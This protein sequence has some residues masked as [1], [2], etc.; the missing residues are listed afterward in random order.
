LCDGSDNRGP[1]C[2]R[3]VRIHVPKFKFGLPDIIFGLLLT[4]RSTP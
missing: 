3:A 1:L 4:A 2:K